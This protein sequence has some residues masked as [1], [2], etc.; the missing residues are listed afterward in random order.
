M[1]PIWKQIPTFVCEVC[2]VEITND[3]KSEAKTL[4]SKCILSM[5]QQCTECHRG[6]LD[7][8][9]GLCKR[10]LPENICSVEGCKTSAHYGQS[11]NR[12]CK[13]HNPDGRCDHEES[14]V[15]GRKTGKGNNMCSRHGGKDGRTNKT[16]ETVVQKRCKRI[17]PFVR[18]V[19]MYR[20]PDTTKCFIHGGI[21][22]CYVCEKPAC[23]GFEGMCEDHGGTTCSKCN[24]PL[25]LKSKNSTCHSCNH[26]SKLERL[27]KQYHEK[28]KRSQGTPS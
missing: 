25:Y 19:D 24:G 1:L 22:C 10:H 14:K 28:K 7:F 5:G 17:I 15:C 9:R 6:T 4:C 8:D 12:Y 2:N 23:V 21:P 3:K 20:V 27:A 26:K 18:E 11:P 16:C 13:N